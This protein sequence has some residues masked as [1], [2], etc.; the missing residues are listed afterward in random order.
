MDV[1]AMNTPDWTRLASPMDQMGGMRLPVFDV[2]KKVAKAAAPTAGVMLG[3]WTLF[4]LNRAMHPMIIDIS[5][6][7]DGKLPYSKLSPV[8][9]KCFASVIVCNVCALFSASGWREGLRQCYNPSSFRVFGAIGLLYAMGDYLEMTSMSSMSGAAYQVLLQSKL[10]ITAVMMRTVKGRAAEQSWAQWSVLVTVTMGMSLFM[11]SQSKGA[12]GGAEAAAGLAGTGFALA[13]VF[14]SCFSAVKADQSLKRFKDLPLYAQLSQL[15]F[16][17]GICAVALA[18]LLNPQTV[19]SADAFFH[20]WNR[21]TLLVVASF[22]AKTVLTMTLLKV[23][24]SVQK[25]IGEAAAV[26]VI[27]FSQVLLPMFATKFDLQTFLAM[28]V[29]FMTVTT[30]MLLKDDGKPKKLEHTLGGADAKRHP[31]PLPTHNEA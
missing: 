12:S 5:K 24:D 10:M 9:A 29:V 22:A 6:G 1:N 2:S 16:S 14:V 8:I 4:V 19:S 30:Y 25:N 28:M 3:L 13:K 23:L 27:Y 18:G 17:W 26:V 7:P 20:G 11:L 21:A 31:R 15:M